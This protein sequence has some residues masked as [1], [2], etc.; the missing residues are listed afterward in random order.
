MMKHTK[1]TPLWYNPAAKDTRRRT[2]E[3][4]LP[5]TAEDGKDRALLATYW[6]LYRNRL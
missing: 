4:T 5:H 3:E 2:H 1:K 6:R